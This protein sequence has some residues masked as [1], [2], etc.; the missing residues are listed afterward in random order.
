[1]VRAPSIL[2]LQQLGSVFLG[3]VEERD[4]LDPMVF[5]LTD[6]AYLGQSC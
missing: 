4:L 2:I 1:M 5:L 3:F 6:V